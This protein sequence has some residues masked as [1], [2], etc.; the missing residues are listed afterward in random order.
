MA[1]LYESNRWTGIASR[2]L[3]LSSCHAVGQENPAVPKDE[4]HN[5][6]ILRDRCDKCFYSTQH[7]SSN[8]QRFRH[9]H[10]FAADFDR[11][12]IYHVDRLVLPLCFISATH[13][14]IATS[15]LLTDCMLGHIRTSRTRTYNISYPTR[16]TPFPVSRSRSPTASCC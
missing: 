9:C 11:S 10:P 13:N 14:T 2:H 15:C 5:S 3:R 8:N 1:T 16:C 7:S 6:A 4:C 12:L